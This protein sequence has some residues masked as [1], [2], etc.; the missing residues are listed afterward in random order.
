MTSTDKLWHGSC[1]KYV[2]MLLG[3]HE[4][5]WTECR[6][7]DSQ[8]RF[9]SSLRQHSIHLS[10]QQVRSVFSYSAVSI[11]VK[12]LGAGGHMS[13]DLSRVCCRLCFSFDIFHFIYVKFMHFILTVGS[14][15]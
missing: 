4:V 12:K 13:Q 15:F 9:Q 3:L 2:D 5:D 14:F 1:I 8:E 10:V 7:Q 11:D 6:V